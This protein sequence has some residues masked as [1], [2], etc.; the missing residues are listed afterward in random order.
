M[1]WK[2]ISRPSCRIVQT[3]SPCHTC[4]YPVTPPLPRHISAPEEVCA[5]FVVVCS[6]SP[7][8]LRSDP[9]P[10]AL[11]PGIDHPRIGPEEALKCTTRSARKNARRK[12]YHNF[13]PTLCHRKIT[14][15][16]SENV[17]HP[18]R[19]VEISMFVRAHYVTSFHTCRSI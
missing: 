9:T 18:S 12:N 13:R 19:H 3:L 14:R 16:R 11:F 8:K 15:V 10:L 5:P 4:K 2:E 7:C 6:F 1:E 17:L